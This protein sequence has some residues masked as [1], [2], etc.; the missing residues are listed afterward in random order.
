MYEVIVVG[1]GASGMTA[2]ICAA[3]N[4][5]KVILIEKNN[6]LGR[7]IAASGNGKCNLTNANISSGFYHD[8]YKSELDKILGKCDLD[9]ILEFM[10]SIGIRC[11]E[12]R[13]YFYPMSEQAAVVVQMLQA[14]LEH[15]R[16]K[17]C[18]EERVTDIIRE[19]G[20]KRSFCVLTDK[21]RYYSDRVILASGGLAAPKLGADGTGYEILQKLGHTVTEPVPALVQMLAKERYIKKISGVRLEAKLCLIAGEHKFFE[22]GEIIFT[23]N[24]VSGIPV[25]QL[26]RYVTEAI[27]EKKTVCLSINVV[28][29]AA[30]DEPEADILSMIKYNPNLP[31]EYLF[32][33][34]CNHKLVYALLCE[35]GI[36]AE[37]PCGKL[38]AHEV[39]RIIH[40]LQ[41]MILHITGTN[42]FE[43][44]QV[45]CGG[46]PLN[47]V[48]SLTMESGIIPGLYITGEL[49][50]VDGICGGYNLHFAWATGILAGNNIV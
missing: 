42:G 21:S 6:K 44:A 43:Q 34:Y 35:A 18:L 37:M 27:K 50:D 32:R 33:T 10:K 24:G 12:K 29:S 49:L 8:A 19:S 28:P 41:N 4:G 26:S 20:D 7:K 23:D 36:D 14:E 13:G 5:K 30:G 22:D 25:F 46:V 9:V 47:E 31:V 40:L 17:I 11:K 45:T 16:V 1:G 39:S 38:K 48:D 3:R 15:L 2:A